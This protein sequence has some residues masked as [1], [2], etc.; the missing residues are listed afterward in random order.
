MA[1]TS[2]TPETALYEHPPVP[3]YGFRLTTG[4][5]SFAPDSSVHPVTVHVVNNGGYDMY[6]VSQFGGTAGPELRVN[7]IH[8]HLGDSSGQALSSTDLI[9]TP[10]VSRF[11]GPTDLVISGSRPDGSGFF[12]ILA[13]VVSIAT[14][15]EPA[16]VS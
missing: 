16:P 5:L 3:G 2:L 11:M 8:L 4:P 14:G 13:E 12:H 1:P 6:D 9:Q 15:G 7:D 10:D